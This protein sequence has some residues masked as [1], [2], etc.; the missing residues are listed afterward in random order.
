MPFPDKEAS[1]PGL[2]PGHQGFTGEPQLL[3]VIFCSN[4][5]DN[6]LWEKSYYFYTNTKAQQCKGKT[7]KGWSP[8]VKVKRN[9]NA[10]TAEA[11]GFLLYR[12]G[13]LCD[14]TPLA[15]PTHPAQSPDCSNSDISRWNS[16]LSKHY[17]CC[18]EES[19]E[20]ER[21]DDGTSW[22]TAHLRFPQ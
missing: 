22:K 16:V 17:H 3:P 18:L 1:N 9:R 13:L 7:S 11:P 12:D 5:A 8:K 15:L 4:R 21:H 14:E 2:Q 20:N 6:I 10:V 19:T